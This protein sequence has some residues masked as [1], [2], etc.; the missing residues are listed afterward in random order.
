MAWRVKAE[1]TQTNFLALL[2]LA[3]LYAL[4]K[5]LSLLPSILWDQHEDRFPQNKR[6]R[7]VKIECDIVNLVCFGVWMHSDAKIMKKTFN[8]RWQVCVSNGDN[9]QRRDMKHYEKLGSS[10]QRPRMGLGAMEI[11]PG[12]FLPNRSMSK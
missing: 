9:F 11:H 8:H 1:Q 10:S 3:Q 12:C 7:K 2:N 4:C 5:K 6:F